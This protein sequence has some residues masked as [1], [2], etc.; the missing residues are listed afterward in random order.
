VFWLS[1][2]LSQIFFYIIIDLFLVERMHDVIYGNFCLFNMLMNRHYINDIGY[3]H[4][5]FVVC[6]RWCHIQIHLFGIIHYLCG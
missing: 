2:L 4:E 6:L 5:Y 1:F 3:V